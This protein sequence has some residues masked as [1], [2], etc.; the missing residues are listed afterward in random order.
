MRSA[1]QC[2]DHALED[3]AVAGGYDDAVEVPVI[4]AQIGALVT[5]GRVDD[6]I[7]GVVDA[8]ITEPGRRQ[9]GLGKAAGGRRHG[10]AAA[11]P[12]RIGRNDFAGD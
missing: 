1:A 11:V 3:A 12:V 7:A 6:R 10:P 8:G 2:L 9:A 5:G 4:L